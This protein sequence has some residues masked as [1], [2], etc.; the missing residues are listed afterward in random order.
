MANNHRNSSEKPSNPAPLALFDLDYTMLGGDSEDMW[1][2]FLFE[3]KM[4]DKEFLQQIT[5]YYHAYEEGFLDIHEYE[6]FCSVR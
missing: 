5:D 2:R 4:V 1:S 3:Q 6:A